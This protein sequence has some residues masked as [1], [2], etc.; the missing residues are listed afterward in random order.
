M[1]GPAQ[2]EPWLPEKELLAWIREAADRQ[3]YQKRLAINEVVDLLCATIN[4]L[5][6]HPAMVR[7]M[8]CFDWINT[9]C[10]PSF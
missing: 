5:F 2:I 6:H 3:A 4:T 8:P 7:S 10:L 9:L 1:R